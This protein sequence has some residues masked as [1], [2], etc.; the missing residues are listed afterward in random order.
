MKCSVNNTPTIMLDSCVH[1]GQE[2]IKCIALIT[3]V[4]IMYIVHYQTLSSLLCSYCNTQYNIATHYSFNMFPS[5]PIHALLNICRSVYV[6]IYPS[7]CN[8]IITPFDLKSCRPRPVNKHVKN[9]GALC[10]S[11]CFRSQHSKLLLCD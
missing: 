1:L 3:V 5:S 8:N 6:Y 4:H 7:F 11:S 10:P 9:S 2:Q